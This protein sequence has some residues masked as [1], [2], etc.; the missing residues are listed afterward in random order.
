MISATECTALGTP[1]SSAQG[2]APSTAQSTTPN[3][4]HQIEQ[5]RAAEGREWARKKLE[6]DI[7]AQ[8]QRVPALCPQD[9]TPLRKTRWRPLQ[10]MTGLGVVNVKVQCGKSVARDQWVCPARAQWSLAAYQR[11]SPELQE[12]ACFAATKTGSYEA[13]AVLMT[14][15]GYPVSDDLIH[16]HVQQCGA[17]CAALVL[18]PPRVPPAEPEFSLVIMM[19]GWLVRA[20]GSHWG[21]KGEPPP[22]AQRVD[23][24]EVKSAV[25][26]RLEQRAETASGRGLLAEKSIVACPPLTTPVD[27]GVSVE[28]E[29]R[30]RGLGRAKKIYVV[31]DGAVW[32]WDLAQDRFKDAVL[33]LDFHHAAQ[34]LWALAH[35][36]H[37][38]GT[39]EARAWVE[40]LLHQLRHGEESR[41]VLTLQQLLTPCEARSA[42]V[43]KAVTR[44]VNYLC[45]HKDH[46][47]YQAREKEGAPM[48][49]GA[50][51]SLCRQ[52]QNRFKACGQFW[53]RHGLT[54][55][56]AINVLFKNQSACH[57]WH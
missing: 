27:F 5:Q 23:W 4:L 50:V 43:Q 35:E 1:Q 9:G 37:G 30:R 31:I 18:P 40:P 14:R 54:H 33:T 57:L 8:A 47:H 16:S 49:S 7:Q 17:A 44:E 13:A 52:L 3:W 29:A 48:G 46:L 28:A 41:V 26:Y 45:N 12:L 38:A 11:V 36:L 42:P 53:S 55:L 24:R 56:L 10:L 19:D 15:F 32:L 20:R 25:I 51:E 2:T 22:D 34:H 6:A 21:K 39:A